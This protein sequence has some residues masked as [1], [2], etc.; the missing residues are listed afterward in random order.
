MG[1]LHNIRYVS[2]EAP[3]DNSIEYD[4]GTTVA[5]RARERPHVA[6]SSS[7]APIFLINGLADPPAGGAGGGNT[8]I[9]G[10]D[11]SFT[12]FVPINTK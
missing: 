3:Y 11:H 4:D 5:F 1:T 2:R 10:A 9:I 8:G 12:S 7:G 6:L